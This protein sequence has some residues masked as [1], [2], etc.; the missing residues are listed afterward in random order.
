MSQEQETEEPS[1]YVM[2]PE[3]VAAFGQELDLFFD[4]L[5]D[6]HDRGDCSLEDVVRFFPADVVERCEDMQN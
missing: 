2:D 4:R 1:D 5:F 6:L 3:E